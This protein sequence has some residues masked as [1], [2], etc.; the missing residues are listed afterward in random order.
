MPEAHTADCYSLRQLLRYYQE[1][2]AS[3][4]QWECSLRD[5]QDSGA[6]D[7]FLMRSRVEAIVDSLRTAAATVVST[8]HRIPVDNLECS[9]GDDRW[10]VTRNGTL[11]GEEM[12]A[13]LDRVRQSGRPRGHSDP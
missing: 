12:Q 7:V 4:M 10:L 13:A 1:L 6:H 8:Y 3:L 9:Q 11:R 2:A 5:G